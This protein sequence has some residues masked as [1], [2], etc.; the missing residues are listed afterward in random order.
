MTLAKFLNQAG[1]DYKA[2]LVRQTRKW[3][4]KKVGRAQRG[5]FDPITVVAVLAIMSILAALM[6]SSFS[7]DGSKAT[8]LLNNM[9]VMSDGLNRAKMDLGGFPNRL[10]VLW[11]K[12]DATAGN[13]FNGVAGVNTWNGNY[14]ESQPV[15]ANNKVIAQTISDGAVIEIQREA[16]TNYAYAYFLR[17]SNVPNAII[18]ELLKKCTGSDSVANATFAN[19]KC[20]ATP[21]TGTTEFGTVDY[22]VAESR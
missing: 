10:S 11:S 20:R 22:K 7:G 4:R 18:T 6:V 12:A 14:V 17:A 2:K 21:G 13:M 8:A 5:A 15:D 9:G 3:E 19:G 16:G 1:R